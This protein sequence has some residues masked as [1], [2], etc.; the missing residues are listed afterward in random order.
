MKKN[1]YV[2]EIKQ[3]LKGKA[4]KQ[5]KKISSVHLDAG[6]F[7]VDNTDGGEEKSLPPLHIL[8]VI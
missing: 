6:T 2:L 7:A 5:I 4:M 8:L 1:D 3:R